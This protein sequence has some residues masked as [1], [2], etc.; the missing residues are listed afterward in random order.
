MYHGGTWPPDWRSFTGH[1]E[2]CFQQKTSSRAVPVCAYV[3]VC[4]CHVG[5]R[6]QGDTPL[7][8]AVESEQTAAVRMLIKEGGAD[9]NRASETTGE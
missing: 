1:T 3:C 5:A 7:M 6:P 4:F 2:V 8:V 9:V